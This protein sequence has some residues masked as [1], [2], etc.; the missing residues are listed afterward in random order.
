MVQAGQQRDEAN[1]RVEASK[2][3]RTR[4]MV[5]AGRQAVEFGQREEEYLH[6]LQQ[7]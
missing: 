5:L 4:T 1:H 3:A 2:E 7:A 6:Q